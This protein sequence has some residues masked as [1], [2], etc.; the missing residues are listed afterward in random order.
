MA[1]PDE[2]ELTDPVITFPVRDLLENLRKGL[3]GDLADLRRDLNDK[4]DRLFGLLDHK[5]DKAEVAELR[6]K[7]STMDTQLQE[8]RTQ[9]LVQQQHVQQRIQWRQWLIPTL[10]TLALVIEGLLQIFVGSGTHG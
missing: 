1:P 10:I 3:A 7:I 9:R 4:L 6:A 8:I 5:A 2:N